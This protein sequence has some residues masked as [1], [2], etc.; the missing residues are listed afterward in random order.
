[1][2]GNTPTVIP[3]SFETYL[4]VIENSIGSLVFK[5]L[6]VEIDGVQKDATEDGYFSC[7]FFV[8]SV[9]T[10]FKY[11]KEIHP[12]RNPQVQRGLFNIC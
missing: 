7:A 11:T 1:M 12:P 8:S 4:A 2:T 9:L 3:L 10:M 6:Y 5:N